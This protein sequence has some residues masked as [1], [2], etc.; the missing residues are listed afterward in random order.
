[1]FER[2]VERNPPAEAVVYHG[3]RLSYRELNRRANQLALE[4]RSRGVRPNELVGLCAE[5]SLELV[6]GIVGILKAGGAYVPL[7]PAY[8]PER[9]ALMLDDARPPVIVTQPHL[10]D[11][12]PPHG[13]EL[14]NVSLTEALD[15]ASD[16]LAP[17]SDGRPEDLAYVIFTSGSTGQ[18][19]GVLVRHV[20]VVRLLEATHNLYDFSPADVWTLCHSFAFDFSVWEL[21]GALLYGGRLVV[22]PHATSRSPRDFLDLL[23]AERVTVLNQTPSAFRQ[24]VRVEE[25]LDPPADL[26]L[27]WIIFGGEALALP[28]L[29]TW[30]DRH[31]DQQPRLV[32]MYGITETTVHVTFRPLSRADL[33]APAGSVIGH[34]IPGWQVYLLDEQQRPVPDGEVGE[35]YVGGNGVAAGYLNRPELTAERFLPDPFAEGPGARRYKSGDLARRLPDGDLVYLGR[36]DHQ[37]KIRGFRVELPEVET[38]LARHADVRA[39]AVLA[40]EDVPG[41][42]WLVAYV[43]TRQT[44]GPTARE[45]RC[46]LQ[47]KL[48][49]HAVPTR[50]VFLERLPLTDNGKVDRGALPSP[51]AEREVGA[52]LVGPRDNCQH[53]LQAIWEE[54]LRVR[55]VGITDDFF[56]LGGNSLLAARLCEEINRVFGSTMALAALLQ[57]RTIERL[58]GLLNNT[59]AAVASSCLVPLQP[60]GDRPPFFCIHPLGGEVFSLRLLGKHVGDC[61]PFYGVQAPELDGLQGSVLRIEDMAAHYVRDLVR[62]QPRGPYYLGGY[63]MGSFVALEMAQQ[64]LRQRHRIAFLGMLDDGPTLTYGEGRWGVRALA[65]FLVNLP[66]WLREELIQRGPQSFLREVRR[67]LR[68]WRRKLGA[69]RLPAGVDVEEALDVSSV[70][71]KSLQALTTHYQVL[72]NYVP[73]P[74]PDRVTLFR[75]QVQPL[76]VC[77][78]PDLGWGRL[79]ASGVEVHV[80]PGGHYSMLQEPHVRV[81]G[82]R[83]AG[84]L[85]QAGKECND[86]GPLPPLEDLARP[87]HFSLQRATSSHSTSP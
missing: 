82:K 2:Q 46:F 76:L 40:R 53:R 4:L 14:V 12:L 21:W 26:A 66:H 70:S 77:P 68:V 49:E 17:F 43:V 72:K 33:S 71:E 65:S 38:A 57:H 15:T 39:A 28:T 74:Y 13:T 81:L 47:G 85:L 3:Q 63:S 20:N 83:L 7:D 5:R 25:S 16:V 73:K 61:Q 30:I 36:R 19:K 50:F 44:P 84:V 11:R 41:D 64:L 87:P 24:L 55:P 62:L 1:V 86:P 51:P 56:E 31:G 78:L 52:A 69:V 79:A 48:P 6:V 29:K 22:V 18:P 27:R 80:V 35:I 60:H 34:P 54:V 10:R 8:P 23:R 9:L 59:G 37:V 42:R 32:N 75:S 45:L 58:S 67:K